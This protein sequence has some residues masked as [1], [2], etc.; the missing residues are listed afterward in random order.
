[1]LPTV[2][3]NEFFIYLGPYFNYAMDN[4]EHKHWLISET[5]VVLEKI[6][7]LP[8]HPR[9]K[10]ELYGKYLMSKISW[11]FRIADINKTFE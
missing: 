5:Q 2:Q 10:L 3:R 4:A 1:M 11:H 7:Q 6:D 9:L 8:L